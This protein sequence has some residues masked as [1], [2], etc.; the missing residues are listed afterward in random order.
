[1]DTG[2]VV[3]KG[4]DGGGGDSITDNNSTQATNK[5]KRIPSDNEQTDGRNDHRHHALRPRLS[6][7]TNPDEMS[8]LDGLDESPTGGLTPS[9]TNTKTTTPAIRID[10]FKGREDKISIPKQVYKILRE[11]LNSKMIEAQLL[12][13]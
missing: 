8:G 11:R 1:M 10:I 12:R 5:R 2:D 7:T 3:T 4:R 13:Q 9:G 6:V